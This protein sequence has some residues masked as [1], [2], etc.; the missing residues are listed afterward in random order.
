MQPLSLHQ[1][2]CHVAMIESLV[3]PLSQYPHP[4]FDVLRDGVNRTTSSIAVSQRNNA[5]PSIRRQQSPTVTFA[6]SHHPRR[7]PNTP[8][9]LQYPIQYPYPRLLSSV[10]CQSSHGLTFSLNS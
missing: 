1:D 7:F 10:Q 8:S 5:L 9:A 6:H 4:V 3:C 2:L